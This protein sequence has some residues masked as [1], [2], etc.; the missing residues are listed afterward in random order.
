MLRTRWLGRVRYRDGHALQRALF[1]NAAD[2]Y[3]LLTEH[4]HVYTLGLRASLDNVLVAPESVGAELVSTNRGGDVT[5]HGPGQL[6]GYP[7]LSMPDA[8][9]ATPAYVHSVEQ[10]VIDTCA[11]LGFQGAGRIDGY[12]GVWVDVEG[13]SPRKLCAIGVRR[14][15]GR[16][17]HGFALNVDPDL[18]YFD[19]IIPCGIRDKGVTSLAAEEVHVTMAQVVDALAARAAARWGGGLTERQDVSVRRSNAAEKSVAAVLAVAEAVPFGSPKPAWLRVKADLGPGFREIKRTMRAQSLVTVCEE[20]GCPNIFECWNAGTATFMINGERC[21]RACGFCLV[22]T[23]RPAAPDPAEA[24]HVA[25]A[26]ERMNL[27]HA[28]I[29]GVARDDLPDGGAAAFAAAIQAV[30]GRCPSTTIEVL[31]PDCKGNPE[32]LHAIFS[33]GP[34]VLNHNL[35]TV[36]RLQRAVRPQA[37]YAR[38][39]AVLGRARDAKLV[40]KSG[41]MVG[42]G[43]S[44]AEVLGAMA[45]LR[46][47][48]V[49]ILT[50]GQYLRPTAEHL[51]VARWWDPAEFEVLRS[52]GEAMGFSHVQSSPLTRSSYHAREAAAVTVGG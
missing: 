28:V 4:P 32:A 51:P 31:I 15:R 30:R 3:L 43:E 39:L 24:E 26:V 9:G 42:M 34:D 41:L 7:I 48:G 11:D 52:A 17:M 49:E 8:P 1:D 46:N 45:D 13:R 36:A 47:V 21:T 14:T 25:E 2:D 44:Q 18:T 12:P 5:Y 20:A 38:S 37:S 23:E 27:A 40:T 6:V 29:T 19:H 16:T 50:L 35:E 10:L 33:A 22:D